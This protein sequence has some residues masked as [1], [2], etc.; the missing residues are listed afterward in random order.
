MIQYANAKE[1]AFI[2][3][4]V[5]TDILNGDMYNAANDVLNF[6][7]ASAVWGYFVADVCGEHRGEIMAFVTD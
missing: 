6:D 4:G 5:L 7:L 1:Y 3:Y 2:V